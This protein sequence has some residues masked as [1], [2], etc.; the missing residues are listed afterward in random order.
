MAEITIGHKIKQLRKTKGLSSKAL[1]QMADISIGMLSQ[2][3]SGATQGSVETLRKIVKV[4]DTTMADLF[5]EETSAQE[6]LLDHESFYVV[7]KAARK[8]L[9]FPDPLYKCELLTPDLQGAIEF[10][11]IELKP[12]YHVDEALPHTRGGEEC[13]FVLDGNIKIEVAERFF[14]L[15]EGDSMR[16][17][18]SIKHRIQNESEQKAVLISAITPPS[19]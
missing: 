17:D 6:T 14:V 4:L 8:K 13:I 11:M 10:I 3:E 1:A 15:H 16:F 5:S 9:N 18:P 7:R 19:F 2:L 12:G